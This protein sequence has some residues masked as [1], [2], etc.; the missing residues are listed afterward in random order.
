MSPPVFV[1]DT[2]VVVA[3]L[4]TAPGTSPVVAMLDAMLSGRLLYLMSPALLQE[5][6]SVLLR[7]RIAKLHGLGEPEVDRVLVE[8]TA[9]AIWRE[10][11]RASP[12]PDP[13]DDHLWALLTIH[14]GSILITGDRLLQSKPPPDNRMISPSAWLETFAR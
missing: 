12:A 6:R 4:V 5:Y 3:G 8:L 13:G 7:P 14:D 9:N 11:G 2:N 1:V 10:P